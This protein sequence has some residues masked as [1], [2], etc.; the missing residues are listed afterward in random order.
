MGT[1][2]LTLIGISK[3]LYCIS[4]KLIRFHGERYIGRCGPTSTYSDVT[5]VQ[6]SFK[7]LSL[8]HVTLRKKME[9]V[10]SHLQPKDLVPNIIK[11]KTHLISRRRRSIISSLN[12]MILRTLTKNNISLQKSIKYNN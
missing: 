7:Y 6:V 11:R 10:N 3:I 1:M 9:L 8:V 2:K 12:V 5:S 4:G